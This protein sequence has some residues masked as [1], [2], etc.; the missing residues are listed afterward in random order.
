MG[1]ARG[2][3]DRVTRPM[4]GARRPPAVFFVVLGFIQAIW[5]LTM[6]LYLPAFP[7]IERDLATVPSLVQATL[8]GAFLG[9]AVG[10]LVAG[11]MSDRVGR[12]RPLVGALVLYSAAT[13]GCA[14][15]P[16]IELLIGLRA[17]QGV[18]AAASSVI[19]LAI[20]RDSREGSAM[21][22]LLARLQ[23]VNGVF[24]VTAPALGAQLL[25]LVDWRGL[26][27]LLVGF[28]AVLLVC[29]LAVLARHETNPPERRAAR[30]RE[31]GHAAA[32][33]VALLRDRLYVSV[34]AAGAL[35]WAA[36]MGYM[37]SSA[38]LFQGV[39]GLSATQYAIVFGGHG[40]LMIVGAQVSAR[41][42]RGRDIPRLARFG[43]LLLAS[44]AVLLLA[45]VTLAPGLG[46]VGLLV[47]LFLF[48]TSF[49]V[50]SPA[51]QTSGLGRHGERAGT[52]AS[53]IGASNMIAGA[54]GAPLVGL[55]GTSTAIPAAA[56]MTVC[57]AASAAVLW[58]GTR[59]RRPRL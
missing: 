53:L 28:G 33:Y 4:S 9:M 41:L 8:T 15:A 13:V 57:T 5:P 14:L 21:V 1:G 31:R 58:L 27:W 25:G 56:V 54:V 24:V 59:P 18:G 23:I 20:V 40:A 30:A 19:I 22:T 44:S 32:D 10:Q 26:M 49:G 2:V 35:Q 52:A 16:T 12:M 17:V 45:S 3:D 11:P 43:A 7:Q 37:A 55:L 6:D 29:T 51:L 47:P 38:F 46:L 34:V 42:S 50:V 48:T 39:Y 36:M